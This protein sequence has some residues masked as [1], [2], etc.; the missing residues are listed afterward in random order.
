[1]Q[2]RAVLP[3]F[4]STL[5]PAHPSKAGPTEPTS[6]SERAT[7]VI[8][9]K[10]AS[11][12]I[13]LGTDRITKRMRDAIYQVERNAKKVEGLLLRDA[14]DV[15]VRP[16]VV[17]WGPSVKRAEVP[18]RRIGVVRV[19]AG[20]DAKR[21]RPLLVATQVVTPETV[22]IVGNKIERFTAR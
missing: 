18:V 4:G 3:W 2:T 12:T 5:P 6:L 22:E 20:A 14:R 7:A 15:P 16:V 13:D 9:T 21:W 1:M 10:Y 11:S 8:E 19:V 17:F